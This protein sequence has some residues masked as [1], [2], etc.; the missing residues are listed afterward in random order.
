MPE[1]KNNLDGLPGSLG[2]LTQSAQTI[3]ETLT[4]NKVTAG[5]A[6]TMLRE[7]GDICHAGADILGLFIK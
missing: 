2:E 6:V 3:M 4:D 5:E 1:K 7:L